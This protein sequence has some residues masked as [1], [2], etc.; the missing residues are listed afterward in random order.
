MIYADNSATT[1]VRPEVLEAMLPYLAENC[2]NAS[3]IHAPGRAARDAVEN[4]REQI[5][6]LINCR[7]DEVFFTPCGTTSNNV[8]ILGRARF[9]QANGKGQHLITTSIEHPSAF[10]PAQFLESQGWS[11]TYLPV[12]RAGLVD[13]ENLKKAITPAAI[14]KE[15]GI[16]FHTDPVQVPG[17]LPIDLSRVAVSSL[18][19]SGH[20]FH[21]PKGIGFLFL[22]QGTNVMPI[23]F[24]GG[25]EH[26]L[27][28][29][30][31]AVADIVAIGKA[32]ELAR[33]DLEESNSRLRR[34]QDLLL[35]KL[36]T[37]QNVVITGPEKLEDRLPGHVSLA[38]PGVEGESL[39]MRLDLQDICVSSGSACHHG[40]I[41]PS[42]VLK[43]IGLSK[44][45]AMGSLRISLGRF[46]S[47]DEL[48][49]LLSELEKALAG[50][51]AR[52][53]P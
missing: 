21:A 36:K 49:K 39:V 40:V 17:K 9:L 45:E 24:G 12:N 2:G 15:K 4:A 51:L 38:V 8:A 27:F 35:A 13:P 10:G 30:T 1:K 23:E 47:D 18:S 6:A 44:N 5:A 11:V 14:A 19:A 41:E 52:A 16:F 37:L 34:M 46:N 22:R 32:A 26:G 33:L 42:H 7:S 31:E 43:A 48:Q 53:T 28:P 29:G 3:S 25:Q 50:K 20:K